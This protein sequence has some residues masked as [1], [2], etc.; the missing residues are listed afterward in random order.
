MKILIVPLCSDSVSVDEVLR[1]VRSI[2]NQDSYPDS[3][4]YEI[5]IVCNTNDMSYYDAVVK[6]V[7]ELYEDIEIIRTKSNGGNGKGHNS[8]LALFR[9]TYQEHG[10]THLMMI[11]ADDFYYPSAFE[12]LDNIFEVCPD[13]DYLSNMQTTD[14]VRIYRGP[15]PAPQP[16]MEMQKNVWLHSNFNYRFPIPSYVYWDGHNCHGGEVTLCLSAK[17]VECDLLHLETPNIPD[18]YT[19]MLWALK[20]HVEGRLKFV[21]TD[22]N[23]VYVYDKTNPVGTTNQPGFMFNP[24]DWPQQDREL[25]RGN[26]FECLRNFNRQSLP[27]VTVPQI[28]QPSDKADFIL[29][30]LIN[31]GQF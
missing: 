18:D 14:S 21:N 5:K 2:R 20:A 24:D 13:F 26:T 25:L 16:T 8:V 4:D 22:T 17:A 10:Y 28:L 3:F 29:T 19:H 6:W 30:N 9:E 7:N 1:C 12:A 15:V 27:W 11:D 23:D 31:K